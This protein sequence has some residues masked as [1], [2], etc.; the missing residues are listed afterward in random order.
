MVNNVQLHRFLSGPE[1]SIC[2]VAYMKSLGLV[3]EITFSLFLGNTTFPLP[4]N[5]WQQ[6]KS[7]VNT[8]NQQQ[9]S[10]AC[11]KS[12]ALS[13]HLEISSSDCLFRNNVM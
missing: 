7:F 9:A 6:Y 5:M 2:L 10:C 1:E 3:L 8:Q 12:S 4:C 13:G 11:Q